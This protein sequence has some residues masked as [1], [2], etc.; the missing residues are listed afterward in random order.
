MSKDR[1]KKVLTFFILSFDILYYQ[2]MAT[3]M[4]Q[5]DDGQLQEANDTEWQCPSCQETFKQ[6]R[7]LVKHISFI[8][9]KQ[10]SPEIL[11]SARVTPPI[12]PTVTKVNVDKEANDL[13]AAIDSD[14]VKFRLAQRLGVTQE[15]SFPI[16]YHFRFNGSKASSLCSICPTSEPYNVLYNVLIDARINY[17]VD[18]VSMPKNLVIVQPDGSEVDVSQWLRPSN[19]R[20][21]R[22]NRPIFDVQETESCLL[23]SLTKDGQTSSLKERDLEESLQQISLDGAAADPNMSVESSSFNPKY[24]SSPAPRSFLFGPRTELKGDD[25]VMDTID[26]DLDVDKVDIGLTTSILN[27]PSF[28]GFDVPYGKHPYANLSAILNYDSESE[29]EMPEEEVSR[30]PRDPP[31]GPQGG[32]GG[33][34]GGPVGPPGVL[35]VGPGGL[36]CGPGGLPVGRGG[37]P[38]GP[39][40][41]PGGPPVVQGGQPGVPAG[42]PGGPAGPPGGPAGPPG[43]PAG[44]PGGPAGPPGGPAWPQAGLAH[45]PQP[46]QLLHPHPDP[47]TD[48]K[49]RAERAAAMAALDHDFTNRDCRYIMT[50][51]AP[52]DPGNLSY[53]QSKHWENYVNKILFP[54]LLSDEE[55]KT[56][57][58]VDHQE[59][60]GLVQEFSV[61]FL[62][63]GGPQG[64]TMK[65][66][67]MTPDAL[68]ALLL[69][70][71]HE[72]INDR[73][74]GV[75]FG[76]S[77]STVNHWIHGLRD[78]IYQHD[79]W[80]QRGRNLSNVG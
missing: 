9:K 54:Q 44:P 31:S 75:I 26:D 45:G 41:M 33:I 65:P 40:G 66:H 74:L 16:L 20:S 46:N 57:Y 72:N 1:I 79:S 47:I 55:L 8:C 58:C 77:A 7:S 80:L 62:Q 48:N 38:G 68:M 30:Q 17:Q 43:G 14:Y 12:P 76:E 35:P 59:F 50:G 70:K 37:L 49:L 18:T 52:R 53:A 3:A 64:G 73:L 69:L 42:P 56:L 22:S 24:K 51:G 10:L 21:E 29:P 71:C 27:D 28:H 6:K 39:G 61:P 63:Q 36:P 23:F 2:T 19:D 78:Y 60:Y 32:P 34:P 15:D 4:R 13:L 11:T 67:R 5:Q 25:E